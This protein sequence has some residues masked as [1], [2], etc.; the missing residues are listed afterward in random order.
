MSGRWL[1]T[2]WLF[3]SQDSQCVGSCEHVRQLESHFSH[4]KSESFRFFFFLYSKFSNIASVFKEITHKV[5]SLNGTLGDALARVQFEHQRR[6]GALG[7]IQFG[8]TVTF[9]AARVAFRAPLLEVIGKEAVRTV[10]HTL[11][12]QSS[13]RVAAIRIFRLLKQD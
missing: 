3:V 7:A 4:F 9:E 12:I 8:G 13:V 2:C 11:L 10:A 1:A 5:A 6:L